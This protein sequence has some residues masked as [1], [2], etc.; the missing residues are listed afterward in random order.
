MLND[1]WLLSS[2]FGGLALQSFGAAAQDSNCSGGS[3]GNVRV[4]GNLNVAAPCQLTGTD[5]DGSVTLFAGGSLIA[6]DVEIGSNLTARRADFVDIERTDI[7]GNVTLDELVGDSSSVE[8]TDMRGNVTLT[9]NRSALEILNNDIGGTLR[10][11][12]NS[13]GLL[14]SGNAIDG[15]L[16]CS[17]NSPAPVGTGNR[18]DRQRRGQCQNLQPAPSA[19]PGRDGSPP[20]LTLLGPAQ[21]TLTVGSPYA[22]AGATAMDSTDG[23]LTARI[24]V[25]NPV[26]TSLVGT[27]TVTYAVS[28]LSGNAAAPVTRT[29]TVDPLPAVGGGGGGAVGW[30]AAMLLLPLVG[31]GLARR[32]RV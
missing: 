26:N 9:N 29:V 14:I 30:P 32:K 31:R 23:D 5:V 4:R 11:T 19:P 6:R 2:V 10:A 8:N 25:S 22:D 13:G 15:Q 16:D 20:T 27:F 24:V 17:G 28:D 7:D 21:V 3:L 1:R 18:V 12:G